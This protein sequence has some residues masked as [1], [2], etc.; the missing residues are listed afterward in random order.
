LQKTPS[1]GASPKQKKKKEREKEKEKSEKVK[2][3][4]GKKI[5]KD[6]KIEKRCPFHYRG[7]ECKSKKSI[8]NWGNRQIWPWNTE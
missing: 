8:N 7:L 6:L 5:E 3:K 4:K 2:K 1:G